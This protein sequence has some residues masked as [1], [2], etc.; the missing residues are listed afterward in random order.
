MLNLVDDESTTKRSKNCV[1]H[2][3]R[4]CPRSTGITEA[5]AFDS[6]RPSSPSD[7]HISESE[8]C[9]TLNVSNA[10]RMPSAD[11]VTNARS[12]SVVHYCSMCPDESSTIRCI[13]NSI[14]D[15]VQR[16]VLGHRRICSSSTSESHKSDRERREW[17]A[18]N[19]SVGNISVDAPFSGNKSLA[20]LG[21]WKNSEHHYYSSSSLTSES[22]LMEEQHPL[23][24]HH[25]KPSDSGVESR[26]NHHRTES[27]D[28]P[29]GSSVMVDSPS[30]VD[31]PPSKPILD[32]ANDP[33]TSKTTDQPSS[34]RKFGD[35]VRRSSYDVM[36]R[37][38]PLFD[39][40]QKHL[41]A[42]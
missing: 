27:S 38:L 21:E 17:S 28:E 14:I 42:S 6:D 29:S 3:M 25:L 19:S 40:K 26:P 11:E 41:K 2:R 15:D 16:N 13:L 7:H 12:S 33:T 23:I 5:I 4:C 10:V 36:N 22:S 32:V 1:T 31:S 35:N 37:H 8:N 24:N 9:T 20:I 30:T 34:V 39:A 18:M